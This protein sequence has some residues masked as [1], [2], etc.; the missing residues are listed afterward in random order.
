MDK[1]ANSSQGLVFELEEAIMFAT[2][3]VDFVDQ[4][5]DVV[6]LLGMPAYVYLKVNKEMDSFIVMPGKP[7]EYMSFK[8][9]ERFAMDKDVK[10]LISK[11]F[12]REFMNTNQ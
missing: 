10:R 3:P 4:E 12:I 6:R 7:K 5:K 2:K 11:S 1:I 9:P 8:V